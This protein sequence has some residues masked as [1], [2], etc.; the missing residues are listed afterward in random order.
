MPLGLELSQDACCKM[1]KGN[2]FELA[3]KDG[4]DPERPGFRFDVVLL[5]IDHSP[6]HVLAPENA[7]F[8]TAEGLTQMAR[9]LKP[10]GTFALWSNDPPDEDFLAVLRSVS[11]TA[12]AHIIEFDGLHTGDKAVNSIYIAQMD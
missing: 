2:F 5:D 3:G 10:G 11:K 12:Q 7:A 9:H 4:F 8:Y 1:I 6:R